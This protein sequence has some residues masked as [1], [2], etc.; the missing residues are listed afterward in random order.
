MCI[1]Q[2][3]QETW[4]F[5]RHGTIRVS[6][7]SPTHT[8]PVFSSETTRRDPFS[9][10]T[11]HVLLHLKGC[12]IWNA[13]MQWVEVCIKYNLLGM[14][15]QI[16]KKDRKELVFLFYRKDGKQTNNKN[17]RSV[18][19]ASNQEQSK[20]TILYIYCVKRMQGISILYTY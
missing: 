2:P 12:I 15:L 18:S 9:K 6:Y 10:F 1:I 14:S 17:R 19:S 3:L 8:W 20:Q 4:S 5:V 7:A 13:C 11:W 16:M